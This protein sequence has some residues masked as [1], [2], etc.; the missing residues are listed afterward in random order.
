V[1]PDDWL[2]VHTWASRPEFCR[3][4]PWGPNT[5]EAS[6]AFVKDAAAAW[7]QSPQVRFPYIANCDGQPIGTGQVW[8]RNRDHRQGEIAYGLHPDLWGHGLGTAIG[9]ELLAIGFAQ[10]GLHRILATC[11]PRNTGSARVLRKLGMTHEG[12]LR[13][14]TLIRDGWRDSEVFST[15]EREWNDRRA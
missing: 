4:Q 6:Q 8:I 13:Q 5:P 2:A 7:T 10:L 1:R 15:L 12:T 11:D 14:T 9:L 3:Y